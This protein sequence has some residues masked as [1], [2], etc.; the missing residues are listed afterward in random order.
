MKIKNCLAV[1]VKL[2]KVNEYD[3]GT[4]APGE[5]KEV[6]LD[7]ETVQVELREG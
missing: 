5:E 6:T 3:E 4:L 2:V 7:T 1:P